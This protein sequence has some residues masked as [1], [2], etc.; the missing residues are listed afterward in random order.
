MKQIREVLNYAKRVRRWYQKL[1]ATTHECT[2]E[3]KVLRDPVKDVLV[4]CKINDEPTDM[5][6]SLVT[7]I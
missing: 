1:H 4:P 5:F 6:A 3:R 2:P 7:L